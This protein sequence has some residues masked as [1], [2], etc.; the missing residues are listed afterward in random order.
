MYMPQVPGPAHQIAIGA[1]LSLLVF[2][3]ALLC[4]NGCASTTPTLIE[5]KLRAL[6]H[7]IEQT[8]GDPMRVTPYDGVELVERV[9]ACHA[10]PGD[11]GKP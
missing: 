4:L 10:A 5:C 9:K 8:D 7:L 11:A 2:G 3:S 6:E 1:A